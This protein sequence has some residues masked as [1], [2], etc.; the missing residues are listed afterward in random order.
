ME[1]KNE[2]SGAGT[3]Q[4]LPDMVRNSE[5]GAA[6]AAS[7]TGEG[8]G[9]EDGGNAGAESDGKAGAKDGGNA[10]SEGGKPEGATESGKTEEGAEKTD[11]ESDDGAEK[12]AGLA[13]AWEG[14]GE[15]FGKDQGIDPVIL[16]DFARS[17]QEMGLSPEQAKKLVD[18]QL[19]ACDK[20]AATMKEASYRE[21][22]KD[23]GAAVDNRLNRCVA[24]VRQIDDHFGTTAFSVALRHFGISN[25]VN[26]VRGLDWLAEQLGEDSLAAV[27]SGAGG[28]QAES[29]LDGIRNAMKSQKRQAD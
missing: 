24:L 2:G 25:D 19:A 5:G 26:F 23:W 8:A 3:D 21:L 22:Q 9:S 11:G 6:A 1:I 15:G 12:G 14:F 20:A 13:K 17:A 28:V 29:P 10:E 7:G 4:V 27:H 18:W 16:K